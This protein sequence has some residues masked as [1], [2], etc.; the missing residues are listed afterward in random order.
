MLL[1]IIVGEANA[2]E[3]PSM[4]NAFEYIKSNYDIKEYRSSIEK[5]YDS[6]I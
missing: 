1:L 6:Q 5:I 4:N 2:S 3:F